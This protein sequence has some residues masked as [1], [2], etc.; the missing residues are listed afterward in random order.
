G[1][2]FNENLPL[3]DGV[4]LPVRLA[5][6]TNV[7][8]Q[9]PVINT[10]QGAM[11]IQEVM[12]RREWIGMSGDAVAYAP[13]LRKSPLVGVP[14]K[15]IIVQFAKGN[16]V[17]PDPSH[18]VLSRCGARRRPPHVFPPRPVFCREPRCRQEST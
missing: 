5:D 3:R 6:G 11:D 12:E 14:A 4:P 16:T 7:I 13:H 1:P 18:T 15:S 9:S 2:H 17:I 8:I 10:V